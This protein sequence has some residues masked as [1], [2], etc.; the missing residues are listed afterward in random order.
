V[1]GTE[2]WQIGMVVE[3]LAES[4]AELSGAL[5]LSW[6]A[7][8]ER[9]GLDGAPLKAV[10]SQQGPP[11][12]ELIEGGPGSKWRATRGFRVDHLAYWVDDVGAER[13]RLEEAGVPV[14][15]DGEAAG[16]PVNFHEAPGSGLRFE[17]MSAEYKQLIRE[18]WQ[19][20]DVG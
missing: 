19:L 9:T 14:I 5:G 12:F 17:I 4:M 2:F 7:P 20:E 13:R 8:Q 3:D 10:M 18:G 1:K 15:A 11:Y 6:G 16:R